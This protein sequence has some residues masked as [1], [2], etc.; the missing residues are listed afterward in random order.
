MQGSAL[1]VH[2]WWA[3]LWMFAATNCVLWFMSARRFAQ[4]RAEAEFALWRRPQLWLSFIYVA[5]CGF[6]SLLPRADVQRICLADTWLSSIALGR[7]V[8]TIAEVAFVIQWALLLRELGT[9][10]KSPFAVAVS[11]LLVPIIL[12]A[13]ICSWYAVVTT[14]FLG[15][16]FEQSLW[17]FTVALLCAA[18]VSMWAEAGATTRRFFAVAIVF[19]ASFILFESTIDVPM[20]VRRF[21][22]DEA[23]GRAYLSLPEGFVDVATRWVV[24]DRWSDW[25]DELAWM[26][27]YFSAAVWM[28]IFMT[29]AP[30]FTRGPSNAAAPARVFNATLKA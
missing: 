21:F 7:T 11:R 28:S 1:W 20:Y 16:A 19:G 27:F 2:A 8:A 22:I 9:Q 3:A 15:H 10:A 12:L 6:R 13:E 17:A 30:R 24:T 18:L 4:R 26:F 14:N 23:A 25:H 29:H 5:G